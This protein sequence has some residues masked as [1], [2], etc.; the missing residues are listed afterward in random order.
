MSTERWGGR[1]RYVT[2]RPALRLTGMPLTWCPSCLLVQQNLNHSIGLLSQLGEMVLTLVLVDGWPRTFRARRACEIR[3]FDR[4]RRP[5]GAA[6]RSGV[7]GGRRWHHGKRPEAPRRVE[8]VVNRC[9]RPRTT[10]RHPPGACFRRAHNTSLH[11]HAYSARTLRA[12]TPRV[13]IPLFSTILHV[14]M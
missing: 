7:V 9:N 10:D 12:C 6:G 3:R 8:S 4:Y 14:Y 2:G 5:R 11:K 1:R 13:C